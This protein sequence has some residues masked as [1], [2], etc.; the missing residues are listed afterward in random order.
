MFKA[1]SDCIKD[2]NHIEAIVL[3][4]DFEIV[5]DLLKIDMRARS[6]EKKAHIYTGLLFCGNCMKPMIRRVNRYKGKETV[7]FIC[8]TKNKSG[9]CTRHTISEK[10]L[11]EIVLT[12]LRQQ[13][14]LFLNKSNVLM[15]IKKMEVNLKEAALF[16]KEIKRLYNEQDKYLTLKA[17]LYKDLKEQVITEEDFKNFREIFEKRDQELQQAIRSQK[18]A[19][20]KFFQSK[21]TAENHLEQ[22]RTTMQ[23]AEL[24]R[25]TLI[26][27][28]KRILI[29][30]DKRVYLEFRYKELL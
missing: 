3:K 20:K 26:S 17:G 12:V 25:V 16:E 5:Q 11:N 18:E 27:L 30:E 15:S 1:K 21:A 19:R 13:I 6:K 7:S 2:V 23:I 14:L 10:D 22:I 9:K 24:D 8:S 28:M 4:E 29:Y